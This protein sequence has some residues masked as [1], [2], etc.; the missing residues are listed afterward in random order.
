MMVLTFTF[1]HSNSAEEGNQ[2]LNSYEEYARKPKGTIK[3]IKWQ[4]GDLVDCVDIYKQPSMNHPLL[5][6]HTI[7]LE[8]PLFPPNSL[9]QHNVSS[10]SFANMP[11]NWQCPQGSV[12]IRRPF[13]DELVRVNLPPSRHGNRSKVNELLGTVHKYA[14]I[15]QE[16][17]GPRLM[18]VSA[19]INVWK[20]ITEQTDFSLAQ[21]WA[22][23]STGRGVPESVEAGWMVYPNR[24]DDHDPR[25][26]IFFTNDGYRTGC[27]NAECP[28]FVQVSRRVCLGC[29][30]NTYSTY[31]GEQFEIDVG[32]TQNTWTKDWWIR[33]N[34]VLVGYYP[35]ALFPRLSQG[36]ATCV[37][38][39]GEV[40]QPPPLTHPTWTQM[41]SGHFPEEGF[42]KAAYFRNMLYEEATSRVYKP[43]DTG[44]T[45]FTSHP[46]CYRLSPVFE[47]DPDPQSDSHFYYGGP[48]GG[49]PD[50]TIRY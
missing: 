41:G 48:G 3:T 18:G 44:V 34:N 17:N 36:G 26:F 6:N 5:K 7:Q 21:L 12:P 35:R 10:S 9:I 15:K 46:G 32:I 20:P 30:F 50:C 25:L 27:Y 40:S 11:E 42:K 1:L 19:M 4:D 16:S 23:Y 13:K 2:S 43:N 39:G 28:G 49:A 14:V 24:H 29:R 33:I 31:N 8:P 47:E 37:E 22:Y 38:W 45:K